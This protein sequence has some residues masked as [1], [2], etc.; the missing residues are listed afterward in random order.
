MLP[1]ISSV[2]DGVDQS[3][4]ALLDLLDGALERGFEIVA[5]FEWAFGVPAHQVRQ[6]SEIRFGI[7]EVDAVKY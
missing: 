4:F 5:V 6:A 2:A 7:V 3:G 1:V